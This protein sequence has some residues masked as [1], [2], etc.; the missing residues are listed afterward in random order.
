MRDHVGLGVRPIFTMFLASVSFAVASWCPP[1]T[2]PL[3]S[4]V[5]L[6]TVH[7]FSLS[8]TDLSRVAGGTLPL[9]E[10]HKSGSQPKPHHFFPTEPVERTLSLGPSVGFQTLATLRSFWDFGEV[11]ASVFAQRALPGRGR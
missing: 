5:Q 11:Q 8:R 6:R 2:R 7:V 10:H 3:S 4:R 1:R 9:A